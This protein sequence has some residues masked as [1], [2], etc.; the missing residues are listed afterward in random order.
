MLAG[1]PHEFQRF[2][3]GVYVFRRNVKIDADQLEYFRPHGSSFSSCGEQTAAM[4]DL[5][6]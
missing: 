6:D 1:D 3:N 5:F 4:S 2:A